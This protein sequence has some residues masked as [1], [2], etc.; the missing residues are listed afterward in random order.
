LF[1]AHL[2]RE[3]HTQWRTCVHQYEHE[4]SKDG[5]VSRVSRFSECEHVGADFILIRG[6]EREEGREEERRGEQ[7]AESREK[8]YP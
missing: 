2:F 1:E 5:R 6:E 4:V 7:R 8:A 3:G